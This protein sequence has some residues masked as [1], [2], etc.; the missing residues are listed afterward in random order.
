MEGMI[1]R[2]MREIQFN[3]HHQEGTRTSPEKW[4]QGLILK[5][6]EATHGQWIYRNIQIHDEVS[7]TQANLQKEA[8]Q[9]EIEAQMELG[10]EGL[11]E[12]D[13]WMLEVNLGILEGFSGEKEEYWLLAI[14]AARTAAT[15]TGQREQ[16]SQQTAG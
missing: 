6:L 8:I 12:E 4:A 9:C 3:Y 5:L 7:G 11:L 16:S 13:H 2:R 14:K 15:L 10:K 1:S